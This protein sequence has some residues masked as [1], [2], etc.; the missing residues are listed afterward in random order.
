[1]IITPILKEHYDKLYRLIEEAKSQCCYADRITLSRKVVY[2]TLDQLLPVAKQGHAF[3]WCGIDAG[4]LA[5]A[6]IAV[7]NYSPGTLDLVAAD[8]FFYSK[9]PGLGR[10]LLR[11]Y[12]EWGRKQRVSMVLLRTSF[13]TDSEYHRRT[14]RMISRFGFVKI[15]ENYMLS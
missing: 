13:S 8:L 5:G 15:G 7:K 3:L 12:V 1:M 11:R 14:N 6:L 2:Q 4:K 9:H 10:K